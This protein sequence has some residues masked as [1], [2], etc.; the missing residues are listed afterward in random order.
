MFELEFPSFESRVDG[1]A[2]PAGLPG[3]CCQLTAKLRSN[4]YFL[5]ICVSITQPNGNLRE[6][7]T[8]IP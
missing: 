7:L 4:I 6:A 1:D 5:G 8:G 2:L 3:V